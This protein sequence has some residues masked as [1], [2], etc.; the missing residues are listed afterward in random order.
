M[1][2]DRKRLQHTLHTIRQV[3]TWQL[4]IILIFMV[5]VTASLYRLNNLNMVDYKKA[6]KGADERGDKVATKQRLLDLQHYVTS[7][8]NTSLNGGI[9][10]EASYDRDRAA[11]IEAAG[12][13]TTNP[14]SEVYKQAS[15][16]CRSR[17]QGGVES[18][19]NDYVTC[20]QARV[21]ALGSSSDIES[22]KLPPVEAYH[23][24]F[25]S[26]LWSADLAGFCTAVCALIVL[27][28]F[29][30]WIVLVILR[31]LLRHRF[32]TV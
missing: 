23:Y 7:H 8:M 14:A 4:L 2:I 1:A 12:N 27:V 20:V 32:K 6:V 19:R 29:S 16:D 3:K 11:A 17:F 25:A 9:Y 15:I 28:I 26:P 5:L 30:R 22:A 31:L 18:Y 24:N 10:L 13:S 21:A